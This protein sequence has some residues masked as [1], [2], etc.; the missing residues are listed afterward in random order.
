MEKVFQENRKADG[1]VK[2]KEAKINEKGQ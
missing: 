2:K 1:E